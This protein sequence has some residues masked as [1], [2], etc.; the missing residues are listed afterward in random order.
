MTSIHDKTPCRLSRRSWLQ[1]ALV[2]LAGCGSAGG[3][4]YTSRDKYGGCP[5]IQFEPSGFF[6]LEKADRWWLVTPEGNAFLSFGLNHAGMRVLQHP[7][8]VDHWLAEFG[9]ASVESETFQKAF[10]NKVRAD[11]D[12][13]GFNSLGT[14][15]SMRYYEQGFSPYVAR[16]VFVDIPHWKEP[17]EK[18][19]LDVFS[20]EFEAH[21]DAIARKTVAP[22]ADD[23]YVIGYSMTDCPIYT[24]EDAAPRESNLYGAKRKGLPT[25]PRVLRNLDAESPGK[26]AYV[27]CVSELY[28]GDINGFNRT[29]GTKLPSFDALAKATNWR[30]DNDPGNAGETRD[31]DEFLRRTVERYYQVSTAV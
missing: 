13:F 23:A 21:C 31:N 8:Y 28:D 7:D 26:Q 29:Y 1:A 11:M 25:W 6:R 3:V 20:P 4:K 30:P 22:N 9:A 18:E 12:A 27:Q 14:H 16:S 24:D 17:A 2:T 19:F 5:D 15:S 10:R